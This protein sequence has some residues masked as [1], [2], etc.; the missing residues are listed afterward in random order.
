MN[1]KVCWRLGYLAAVLSFITGALLYY[2]ALRYT[3]KA[4][5]PAPPNHYNFQKKES[6]YPFERYAPLSRGEMFFGKVVQPETEKMAFHTNLKILGMIEGQNPRAVVGL[7]N[8][9]E[10]TW[11]VK[12]GSVVED[13][14]IVK[15]GSGF[16]VVKNESG[17]GKVEWE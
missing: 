5:E 13:E 3:P 15:I 10:R 2:Q 7:K 8:D 11:I 1:A 4:P 14:Q 9:P 16:I 17:Q 12:P 6:T